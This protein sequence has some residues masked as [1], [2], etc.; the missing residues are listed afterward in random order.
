[1]TLLEESEERLRLAIEAT[2]LGTWDWDFEE[3]KLYISKQAEKILGLHLNDLNYHH[4]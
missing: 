2:D 4:I 3:N 1:M